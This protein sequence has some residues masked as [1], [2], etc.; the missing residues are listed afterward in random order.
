MVGGNFTKINKA[1]SRSFSA[2]RKDIIELKG[3]NTKQEKLIR[4][5]VKENSN[6]KKTIS[7]LK[8]V[9]VV[10]EEHEF[11]ERRLGELEEELFSIEGNKVENREFKSSINKIRKHLKKRDEITE[12]ITEFDEGLDKIDKLNLEIKKLKEKLGDV[13]A[14]KKS[15]KYFSAAI[16][17]LEKTCSSML[18]RNA[19]KRELNNIKKAEKSVSNIKDLLDIMDLKY[20][21]IEEELKNTVNTKEFIRARNRIHARIREVEKNLNNL[22]RKDINK[23]EKP[24]LK[25]FW[26]GLQEFFQDEED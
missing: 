3:Q 7:E 18:P 20:D 9:A 5:L 19:F 10:S 24:K 4:R 2:V 25:R 1:L 26:E 11:I 12:R 23:S 21:A 17:N 22:S 13:E 16:V 14:L 15:N 6:L 8:K